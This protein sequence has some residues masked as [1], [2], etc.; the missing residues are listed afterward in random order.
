MS[1]F[2]KILSLYEL[3]PFLV[4]ISTCTVYIVKSL[5]SVFS[6]NFNNNNMRPVRKSLW[7]SLQ[8]NEKI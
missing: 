8:K 5:K 6:L 3:A 4:G 1:L 2:L 7:T